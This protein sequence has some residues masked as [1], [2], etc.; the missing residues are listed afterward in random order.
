MRLLQLRLREERQQMF[1][2]AVTI[3]DDDLLATIARHLVGGFLQELQLHLGAVSDRAGFM[4]GFKDL[5][6]VI[7][8]KHY[9]VFLLGGVQTDVA[10]I[11]QIGAQGQVSTMLLQ[12]AEWQQ[13]STVDCWIAARKSAAVSSSQ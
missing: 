6:E 3:H 4:H 13:A 9:S 10:N 2:A 7:F 1:V 8:G 11:Q 5:P 12:N